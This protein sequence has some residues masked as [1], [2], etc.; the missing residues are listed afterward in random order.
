MNFFDSLLFVL[1]FVALILCCNDVIRPFQ[2]LLNFCS[3]HVFSG[4]TNFT[5]QFSYFCK[6][7]LVFVV[8]FLFV[9]LYQFFKLRFSFT[10]YLYLFVECTCFSFE[11]FLFRNYSSQINMMYDWFCFG[12]IFLEYRR[13]TYHHISLLTQ[14]RGISNLRILCWNK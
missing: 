2:T 8:Y 9:C 13:I 3:I 7:H 6:F 4:I 14:L 5:F 11:Y 1:M 12:Y 10:F